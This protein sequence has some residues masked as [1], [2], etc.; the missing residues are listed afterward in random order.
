M[1]PDIPTKSQ[2]KRALSA[3]K[4]I[5]E[6]ICGKLKLMTCAD[7]IPQRCYISKEDASSPTIS[8]GS[9]FFSL[10]IYSHEVICADVFDV[11]GS[12]LNTDMIGENSIVLTIEGVF[13]DIIFEVNPEHKK[14]YVWKMG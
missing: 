11:P 8:L 4:M 2:K 13:V 6:K 9:L 3:I 1:I 10:V 12:Y 7:G 5:E 14:M